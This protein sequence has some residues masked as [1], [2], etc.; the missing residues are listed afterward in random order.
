MKWYEVELEMP[1]YGKNF[2]TVQA[3]DQ[4]NAKI[5]AIRRTEINYNFGKENIFV[6]KIK[7]IKY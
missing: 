5:I 3:T 1:I 7:E 4:E 2:E 6:T